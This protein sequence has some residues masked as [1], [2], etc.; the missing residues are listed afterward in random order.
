MLV[1]GHEGWAKCSR[2]RRAKEQEKKVSL[3]NHVALQI[4]IEPNV[5]VTTV[6]VPY[7]KTWEIAI[8]YRMLKSSE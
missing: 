4:P 7:N 1:Q 2:R 8:G 3:Y 5:I 6:E